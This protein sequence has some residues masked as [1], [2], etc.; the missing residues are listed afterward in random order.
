MLCA[1]LES[2]TLVTSLP[3]VTLGHHATPSL[4]ALTPH[5]HSAVNC[6]SNTYA[7]PK[8]YGRCMSLLGRQIRLVTEQG[9][10]FQNEIFAHSVDLLS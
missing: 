9:R 2:I 3:T 5:S 10:R 7:T 8:S 4:C 6:T 1:S